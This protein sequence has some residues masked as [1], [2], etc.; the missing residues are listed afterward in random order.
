MLDEIL[1][2]VRSAY[3]AGVIHADL[4]EFNIMVQDNRPII[5]DWPQWVETCHANAEQILIKD[6]TTIL[7]FFKRKYHIPYT[8]E[9]ALR[10]VTG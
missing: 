1:G 9:D 4:S 6:L 10:C 2:N 8:P 3:R 7:T 5:I